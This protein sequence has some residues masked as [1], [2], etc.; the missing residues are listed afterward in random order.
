MCLQPHSF[1]LAGAD[2]DARLRG[3]PSFGSRLAER[4]GAIVVLRSPSWEGPRRGGLAAT[5]P[6]VPATAPGAAPGVGATDSSATA[7]VSP[8]AA[9]VVRTAGGT[10]AA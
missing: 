2:T 3:G 5:P 7:A 1:E 9:A 8:A 10:S 6:F 4:F